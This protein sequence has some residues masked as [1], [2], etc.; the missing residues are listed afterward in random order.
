MSKQL[1]AYFSASGVTAEVAEKL[2]QAIGADFFEIRPQQPYTA[3][4]LDWQDQPGNGRANAG[5]G[6]VRYRVFR[7]PDLVVYSS[8]HHSDV[9]GGRRFFGKADCAVCHFGRQRVGPYGGRFARKLWNGYLLATGQIMQW[10]D[11][12]KCAG[13]MGAAIL[14][15]SKQNLPKKNCGRFCLRKIQRSAAD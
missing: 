10:P 15:L 1:V 12:G 6:A 4:D 14:K 9:P 8:A 5:Y 11:R 13:R 2:A 7:I 3:A